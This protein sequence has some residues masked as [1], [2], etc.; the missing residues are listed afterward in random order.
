MSW[1]R[2]GLFIHTVFPYTQRLKQED[3]KLKFAERFQSSLGDLVKACAPQIRSEKRV[4]D[5]DK[6]Y[7]VCLVCK[8]WA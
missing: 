7:S 2:P 8:P 3:C 4:R 1:I 5:A 6:V